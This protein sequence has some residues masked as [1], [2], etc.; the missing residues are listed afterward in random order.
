MRTVIGQCLHQMGAV[1]TADLDEALAE[2]G[3]SG[4]R[5]GSV[6]V[7]MNLATERQIGEALAHQLGLPF[8]DLTERPLE[9]DVVLR[10]Q[11]KVAL[12]H[13][14]I[15]I[16]ADKN[17]LTVAMAEP[18]LFAVLQDLEFQTG[19]RIR[20]VVATRDDIAAAIRRGYPDAPLALVALSGAS[21]RPEPIT[22]EV[23]Q[24]LTSSTWSS[25]TTCPTRG[26]TRPSP[27]SAIV[28][29]TGHC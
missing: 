10:V 4:E 14:C 21:V 6:L 25:P 20:Q 11:K 12:A 3:R 29:R 17:I 2:H 15:A 5:L 1:T 7:R 13:T 22:A 26:S 16:A 23:S 8:V 27:P 24:S 18:S 9:A 28:D 19:C